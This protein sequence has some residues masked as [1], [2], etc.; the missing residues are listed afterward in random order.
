MQIVLKNSFYSV[1]SLGKMH[2]IAEVEGAKTP[3]EKKLSWKAEHGVVDGN[4]NYT[5]PKA[6]QEDKSDNVTITSAKDK[7]ISATIQINVE[8]EFDYKEFIKTTELVPIGK[9]GLYSL[10]VQCT[11]Y[12][13]FGNKCSII[14]SEYDTD[15]KS[16]LPG[17]SDTPPI[18]RWTEHM[19]RV[20]TSSKGFVSIPLKKFTE[21]A[22]TIHVRIKG[23]QIDRKVILRGPKPKL[24][25]DINAG[26]W[27]NANQQF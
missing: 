10:E 9:E 22:R 15:L 26:F 3:E 11:N 14:V 6:N 20:K 7:S 24:K 13:G 16:I 25:F 4:G 21:K 27:A 23:T 12:Y 18:A 8:A 1:P 17:E 2:L 5:A 19:I